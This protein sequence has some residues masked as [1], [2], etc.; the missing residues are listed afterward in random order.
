M[1]A[2][3]LAKRPLERSISTQPLVDDDAQRILVGGVTRFASKL[4][5]SH[6]GYSS[7]YFMCAFILGEC[8]LGY[9]YNA[10]VAQQDFITPPEQHILRL[11]IAMNELLAMGILQGIGDLL[12][13]LHYSL[14]RNW[15]ASKMA[16]A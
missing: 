7:L 3:H 1:L 5:R 10:K 13:I 4:L 8:I 11:H 2:C 15:S 16:L 6:V 14:Q 12:D 9:L